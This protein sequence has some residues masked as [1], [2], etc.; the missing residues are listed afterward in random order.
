MHDWLMMNP[1]IPIA[2]YIYFSLA[3]MKLAERLKAKRTWLAWIPIANIYLITQLSKK[4][5][6]TLFA[7]VIPYLNIAA[8]I[9]WFWKIC[10]R[11]NRPEWWAIGMGVPIVNL[12]LI[13]VLAWSKK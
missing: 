4:P 11:R 2:I 6:W 10:E 7:I 3:L 5:W 13:G 12:V 1:A 8:M 9:W